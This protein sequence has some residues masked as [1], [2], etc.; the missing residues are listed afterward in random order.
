MTSKRYWLSNITALGL[1]PQSGR[2]CWRCTSCKGL[3]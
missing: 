2:D 1:V 3:G